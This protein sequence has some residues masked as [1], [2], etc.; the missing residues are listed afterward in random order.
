METKAKT[1]KKCWRTAIT[2]LLGSNYSASDLTG[3]G[4]Q[5][6]AMSKIGHH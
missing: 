5:F 3:E 2:E 4:C 1:T 6:S